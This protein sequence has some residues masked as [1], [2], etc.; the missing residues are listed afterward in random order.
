MRARPQAHPS[1]GSA[2]QAKLDG[3]RFDAPMFS[4]LRALCA[5]V[6]V[7]VCVHC[8]LERVERGPAAGPAPVA[9]VEP[10]LG[11]A[12]LITVGLAP[13]EVAAAL[14]EVCDPRSSPARALAHALQAVECRRRTT[15][16]SAFGGGL[17]IDAGRAWGAAAAVPPGYLASEAA[18][19]SLRFESGLHVGAH[20]MQPVAD[21]A[22]Q[23]L[24]AP[25]ELV[26]PPVPPDETA[27]MP[28]SDH[29]AVDDEDA[30]V[31]DAQSAA[32]VVADAH[33]PPKRESPGLILRDDGGGFHVGLLR[34]ASAPLTFAELGPAVPQGYALM[35]GQLAYAGPEGAVIVAADAQRDP[36]RTPAPASS[37]YAT[38]TAKE[39]RPLEGYEAWVG[40]SL[41]TASAAPGMQYRVLELQDACVRHAGEGGP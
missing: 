39:G 8:R 37:A 13:D 9:P 20:V 33:R 34:E 32:E 17:L 7:L 15:Q 6:G 24:T 10:E 5:V 12:T 19:W 25:S 28:P 40:L 4:V 21:C 35:P 27:T 3:R 1:A 30:G 36:L 18:G 23:P 38:L 14:A 29:L 26:D 41:R 16:G 2:C 11:P 31:A 22:L